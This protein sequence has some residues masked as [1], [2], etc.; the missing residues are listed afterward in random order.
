MR[1]I[2]RIK[3]LQIDNFR[4]IKRLQRSLNTD[5]DVVLITGPNGFGKTSLVDA[6]NVLLNGYYYSER[7]SLLNIYGNEKDKVAN[8]IARVVYD[9][10]NEKDIHVKVNDRN[11]LELT[12][13]EYQWPPEDQRE[14]VAR[15]SFFYQDLIDRLFDEGSAEKTLKEFLAPSP[16]PVRD[17]I[18]AINATKK[19]LEQKEKEIFDLPGVISQEYLD[20][21][22]RQT[23]KEFI[24]NWNELVSQ[25]QL[26]VSLPGLDHAS[27]FEDNGGLRENWPNLL[28]DLVN[29]DC[30]LSPEKLGEVL[31]DRKPVAELQKLK[32]VL[33]DLQAR[34]IEN[35]QEDKFSAFVYSLPDGAVLLSQ[36]EL[37]A[38]WERLNKINQ[39]IT[40]HAYRI[41]QYQIWERHFQ[42]P[43]GPGL[44]EILL[45]LRN[46]GP[47]WLTMPEGDII[48]APPVQVIDWL[49][50]A[51]D[52]LGLETKSIDE[53]MSFWQNQISQ[54][55]QHLQGTLRKQE[56]SYRES[57]RIYN[58]SK[59]M[60]QLAETTPALKELI[61]NAQGRQIS[62][63]ILMAG[64]NDINK[65]RSHPLIIINTIIENISQWIQ[66]EE[67]NIFREK[68]LNEKRQSEKPQ[69]Y[70]DGVRIAL[71]EE[72]SK[73]SL[74][75]TVQ[76]LPE[77]TIKQFVN[78][79]N[80]IFSRFRVVPG[81]C[82][83][84]MTSGN[85][86]KRKDKVET[87]NIVM[88]D[89]RD[90]STLSS[91]QKAQLGLSLLLALNVALDELMPH[92]VLAL[93]DTTTAFDMAQLPRE[94]SLLRQIVYGA[95]ERDEEGPVPPRRQLFIVSH[96]EDLT[97]RLLDFLIPPENKSL[98]IFNFTYWEENG[99]EIEQL[100][101]LPTRSVDI[102]SRK[103]FGDFL[104]S[105]L[106]AKQGGW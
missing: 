3:S 23:V 92:H 35:N 69:R 95:D 21:Q 50:K 102:D 46:K 86:G 13:G 27:W 39:S 70:L 4:G 16:A 73:N 2:Q 45:A 19:Y 75:N 60:Y 22:R 90:L 99:P 80:G 37:P 63:E 17:S 78:M 30:S 89:G 47:E 8:I 64:L 93:D 28:A 100:V 41:K 14:I 67:D 71:D 34:I 11:L 55:L 56:N 83:V 98:H 33:Q 31:D 44:L 26:E 88:A 81:L 20:E 15:A 40:N 36:E 59:Q 53:Y 101:V 42:N 49:K 1:K 66:L 74:I 43:D 29:S 87:W 32:I 48:Y 10:G 84:K 12:A 104:D 52:S 96:H 25:Y 65:L 68:T 24:K 72:S 105:V 97:H 79:V 6:L 61:L 18:K 91:G 77:S 38:E 51:M 85:K 57:I 9:D 7:Q 76:L 106:E 5:A 58:F 94:A 54:E 82:P 62:K 103:E